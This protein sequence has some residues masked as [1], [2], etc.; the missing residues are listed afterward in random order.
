M[1]DLLQKSQTSHHAAAHLPDL[2]DKSLGGR[3]APMGSRPKR[4][5]EGVTE[6]YIISSQC[7]PRRHPTG[8]GA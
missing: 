1:M 4:G 3:L 2:P 7:L 5:A 6:F 8:A